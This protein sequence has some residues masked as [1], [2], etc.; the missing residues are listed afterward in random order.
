[1]DKIK[2]ITIGIMLLI[3]VI[4]SGWIGCNK[5][6]VI[7][8]G[9]GFVITH[10]TTVKVTLAPY[11]V[12]EL[13]T[14]YYPKWD[15]I[16]LADSSKWNKDLCKFERVYIDSV[17]DSNVTIFTDIRTI[18]I[19]KSSQLKYRL[20]VPIRIETMIKTDSIYKEVIPNKW[21]ILAIGGIGGNQHQFN[22]NIGAAIR[23]NRIYY[24]YDY[25]FTDK[26][27]NAKIGIV[28]FKSKK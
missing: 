8:E 16:K 22:V 2:N 6:K 7:K 17:P 9:S 13:K 26:T 27:H 12:V 19:L 4:L 20:K 18:G 11:K 21:D 14:Q 25:S 3:I 5:P 24:A 1:M 10:D 28:L 15:T 23:Y